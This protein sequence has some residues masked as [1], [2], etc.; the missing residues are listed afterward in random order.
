MAHKEDV[1]TCCTNIENANSKEDI[2]KETQT[3]RGCCDGMEPEQAETIGTCCT[4][5]ENTDS[6][7]VIRDEVEKIR[8]CCG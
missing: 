8:G 5:I 1:Q 7:D 6:K 2:M 4:N 3:L